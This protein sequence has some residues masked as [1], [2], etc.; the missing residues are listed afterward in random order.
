MTT[1]QPARGDVWLV[2]LDPVRGHEQAGTRPALV[3]SVDRF[4]LGPAGLVVVLPITSRSK[5]VPL[6]VP[7]SPPEGGLTLPSFVKCEDV[8][9]VSVDRLVRPLGSVTGSTMAM[10]EDRLRILL[11]L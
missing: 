11:G 5:S 7:V 3:V 1:P 8:R 9:S 6:H 4:N 2:S 10:V